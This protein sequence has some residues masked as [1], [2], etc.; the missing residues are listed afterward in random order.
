MAKAEL[1][2]KPVLWVRCKGL[3]REKALASIGN[4]T[5]VVNINAFKDK[6]D[7]ER[8][9]TLR[10]R[11]V[12]MLGQNN[13][14]N[15]ETIEVDLSH[16]LFYVQMNGRFSNFIAGATPEASI[17]PHMLVDLLRLMREMDVL[18][19]DEQGRVF[20][21]PLKADQVVPPHWRS[22]IRHI[23]DTL[24]P[25]INFEEVS[26]PDLIH[27]RH[28]ALVPTELTHLMHVEGRLFPTA[29]AEVQDFFARTK[30]LLRQDQTQRQ[31]VSRS[32]RIVLGLGTIGHKI[33]VPQR[34]RPRGLVGEW[35]ELRAK[36]PLLLPIVTMSMVLRYSYARSDDKRKFELFQNEYGR[37]LTIEQQM[38]ELGQDG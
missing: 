5:D 17:V 18:P 8:P 28:V 3:D 33:E 11:N 36:Y 20:A 10:Q 16:P 15:R 26:H 12:F 7:P 1:E 22:L 27:G 23:I 19:A 38:R 31:Q 2:G 9:K 14:I 4:P 13:A 30:D 25:R 24:E 35:Q 21:V 32:D 29:P 34:E 37:L 6:V